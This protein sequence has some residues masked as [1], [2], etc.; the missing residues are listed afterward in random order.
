MP[1]CGRAFA[2]SPRKSAAQSSTYLIVTSASGASGG[3]FFFSGFCS[4]SGLPP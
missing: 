4:F 1:G 3:R 2:G